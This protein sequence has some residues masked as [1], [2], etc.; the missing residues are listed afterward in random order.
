MKPLAIIP[1]DQDLSVF[2]QWL[3]V[4]GILH[5]VIERDGEQALFVD[6]T[7]LSPQ[8]EQCLKRYLSEGPF[9][10]ELVVHIKQFKEQQAKRKRFLK[11]VNIGLY[12]RAK[13]HEA[14]V[15]FCLI[16]I[17]ILF[18]FLSDFGQGGPLLR[19]FL[20]LDPFKLSIDLST[21]LGRWDALIEMLALGEVWRVISPD[22]IHF[23]AMHITF[24]LLMLWV[25]GGQLEIQ[26]GSLSFIAL[27]IFVSIISNIAQLLETSY[28]FGGLSGVVYGLVGYCWLWKIFEPRIFFPSVL[29][30]FS[31]VWL[32]LGYTPLTEWLG[33]GRMANAAHLY[34]L[35]A[36][37]LWGAVTLFVN[38]RLGK[39][40]SKKSG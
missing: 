13:P 16:G 10:E 11:P 19:H 33:W 40:A 28:L 31:V 38:D 32:L 37:L 39:S 7:E 6:N 35:L 12:T 2:S 26:K 4:Q 15:I 18:A 9:R 22:F 5:R 25:L 24:N 8:V 34:G 17:S 27:T 20:I 3:T 23:N 30:K 1:L 21:A 29:M 36:G 14:P